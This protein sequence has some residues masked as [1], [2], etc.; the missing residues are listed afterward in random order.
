M[1]VKYWRKII[2]VT[3]GEI[4]LADLLEKHFENNSDYIEIHPDGNLN[5]AKISLRKENA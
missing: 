5:S 1:P 3:Q 2:E 4:E